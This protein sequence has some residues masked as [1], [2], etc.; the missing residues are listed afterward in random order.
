MFGKDDAFTT[1]SFFSVTGLSPTPNTNGFLLT[2]GTNIFV[3]ESVTG[4]N[5]FNNDGFSDFA[6]A[7]P[8]TNSVSIYYGSPS[9]VPA[10][11]TITGIAVN[12]NKDMDVLSLGNFS[13]TSMRGATDLAIYESATDIIHIFLGENG[14]GGSRAI[15]SSDI[16]IFH[17]GAANEIISGGTAG[18]FNGDGFKDIAVALQTGSVVDIYVVNGGPN[19]SGTIDLATIADSD[20]FRMTLDLSGPE[21]NLFGNYANVNISLSTM[22]DR[23]ND[24][25]D[26]LMIGVP[27]ADLDGNAGSHTDSGGIIV[28]NGRAED[29]DIT[30]GLVRFASAA[31]A[32]GQ[33]LNGTAGPNTFND[34]GFTNLTFR[35]G[36]GNDI[37]HMTTA[38]Q[39]AIDGGDGRDTLMLTGGNI[40][41]RLIGNN[42]EGIEVINLAQT[43]QTVTIGID[44]IFRLLQ[45]SDTGALI[46]DAGAATGTLN[47][48]NNGL[49]ASMTDLGF[50]DGSSDGLYYNWVF[51]DAGSG[52]Y[53][54]RIDT[55]LT[56][57]IV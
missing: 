46:F 42:L 8:G 9:G 52:S 36:D 43:S 34:G 30:S 22:G 40:D 37:I 2:G 32:N 25:F 51:A 29:A 49:G 41:L 28:V 15:G 45:E 55:D 26:D 18:D 47:I 44:D 33:T 14:G 24:G 12:A 23:N 5:D 4:L 35:G 6:I 48:D 38:T 13:E 31:T 11:M 19:M 7:K 1:T 3:G 39:R 56:T 20:V 27:N 10:S 21:F 53:T 16:R 17:S 50:T 57:G 54:L